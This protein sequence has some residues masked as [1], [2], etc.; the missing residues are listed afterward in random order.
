MENIPLSIVDFESDG[1]QYSLLIFK[2]FKN[3]K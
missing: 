1:W 2:K 3:F